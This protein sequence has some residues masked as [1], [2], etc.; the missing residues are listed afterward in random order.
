MQAAES[1][2]PAEHTDLPL[3]GP[4]SLP[5]P[6]PQHHTHFVALTPLSKKSVASAESQGEQEVAVGTFGL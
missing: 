4:L 5:A 6:F 3:P 2:G 1:V